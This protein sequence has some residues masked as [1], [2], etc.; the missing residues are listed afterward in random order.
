MLT[1]LVSRRQRDLGPLPVA[2]ETLLF[3]SDSVRLST[4]LGS[5]HSLDWKVGGTSS[6]ECIQCFRNTDSR[7][8]SSSC[9]L[10]V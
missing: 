8:S 3:L 4:Q 5:S 2:L 1:V 10:R 6:P 9:Y 7:C